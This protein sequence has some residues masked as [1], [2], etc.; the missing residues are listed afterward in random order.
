MEDNNKNL[1]KVL[2]L[3]ERKGIEKRKQAT[4]MAGILGI[5]Y[6]SAK[7]KLDGMRGV[8]FE[9]VRKIYEYFREAYN[10]RPQYNGIFIVN[11]LHMRCNIEVD[12]DDIVQT[13]PGINY[14][15]KDGEYWIV[16]PTSN[17]IHRS[18][19]KVVKME[20]LP[21]PRI[22]ILDNDT[23]ILDL[24]NSVANRF[25]IEAALFRDK[26]TM[27]E[28]V[29][30]HF[31]DAYVL[32]WLLD[33]EENAGEIIKTIRANNATVPIIIL[34]AQLD[35]HENEIGEII[36]KQGVE[37]LEKPSRLTI[38]SSILISHLFY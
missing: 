10:K 19:K 29:K 25:G 34:T 7:Q 8:R 5:Q 2:E 14:A 17:R 9:E 35:Q 15:Y 20:V 21:A 37:I 36:A 13:E 16:N 11:D 3:F 24:M 26:S 12:T 18:L 30:R 27:L 4:T 28:H 31:Y 32:D 23:E 33:F 38:I 22:A 6:K 1:E